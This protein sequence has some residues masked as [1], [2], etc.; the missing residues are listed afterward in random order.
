MIA[1][2]G[3]RSRPRR[4]WSLRDVDLAYL[5]IA[6]VRRTARQ[7][8]PASAEATFRCLEDGG[9]WPRWI[10]QLTEVTWTS[11]LGVGAT[12]DVVQLRRTS[13]E[14]FIAWEDGRRMSLRFAQSE[15]P[16]YGAFCEDYLIEPTGPNECTLVWRYG[17]E[18]RGLFRLLHPVLRLVFRRVSTTAL[19]RL[20]DLMLAERD[21]Y[22]T[23]G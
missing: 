9:A 1:L 17:L 10:T 2:M 3:N 23:P 18:G 21:R 19:R 5:D 15:L 8:I 4:R 12:R 14:V 20:A 13:S 6:P 7:T 22:S 11:P 16:V